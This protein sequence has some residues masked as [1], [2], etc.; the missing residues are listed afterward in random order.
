MFSGLLMKESF[1]DKTA[2]KRAKE[3]FEE[4]DQRLDKILS[5]E[6]VQNSCKHSHL[7]AREGTRADG[8]KINVTFCKD[9]DAIVDFLITAPT[10]TWTTTC[11]IG[12]PHFLKHWF[13]RPTPYGWK[14]LGGIHDF[15][16][17][18]RHNLCGDVLHIG[19]E[20]GGLFR[21][22][23]RCRIRINNK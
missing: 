5:Q 7:T 1:I 8:S 3:T 19:N 14:D 13:S 21:F 15:G 23:A 16:D 17:D 22:C 6:E 11:L 2:I 20:N 10:A 9:C 12:F 18:S 4:L